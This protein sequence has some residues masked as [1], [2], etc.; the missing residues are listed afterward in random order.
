[1]SSRALRKLQGAG[2]LAGGGGDSGEESP[3]HRQAG[4]NAFSL[5]SL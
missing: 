3:V 1:M 4:R 5:V 2:E